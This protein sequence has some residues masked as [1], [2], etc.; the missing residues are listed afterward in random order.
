MLCEFA[1]SSDT[2]RRKT[3]WEQHSWAVRSPPG[4]DSTLPEEK[5]QPGLKFANPGGGCGHIHGLLPTTKHDLRRREAT[6]LQC[7]LRRAQQQPGAEGAKPGGSLPLTQRILQTRAGRTP[8]PEKLPPLTHTR[9]KTRGHKVP[10]TQPTGTFFSWAGGTLPSSC[11]GQRRSH[12]K[13]VTMNELI[14]T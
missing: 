6:T 2:G 12:R 8:A 3:L 14:L 10:Q 13:T 7:R 4:E 5:D 1:D 9:L 11:L